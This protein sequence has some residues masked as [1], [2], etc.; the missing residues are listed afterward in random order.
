M[1]RAASHRGVVHEGTRGEY[2]VPAAAP[3]RAAPPV[4]RLVPAEHA[5]VE[6]DPTGGT[7]S[8]LYT[9][10]HD[11]ILIARRELKSTHLDPNRARVAARHL[12]IGEDAPGERDVPRDRDVHV[13]TGVLVHGA[14]VWVD[15]RDESFLGSIGV[16]CEQNTTS[17]V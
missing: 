10:Q 2:D 1:K 4:G 3:R 6:D 15:G 16:R 17:S 5:L 12:V 7:R 14:G 8:R 11:V 9:T 13:L